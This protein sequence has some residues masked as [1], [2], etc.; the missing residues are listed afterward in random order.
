MFL[1]GRIFAV[2]VFLN[3]CPLYGQDQPDMEF[4]Q[5]FFKEGKNL[6]PL[7]AALATAT[8]H[9][10][11][12]ISANDLKGEARAL[13]GLGLLHLTRTH[14]YEKAM[15]FLIRCLAIEDS[16]QL[17]D[18]QILT[19]VG[20]AKVFEVVGDYYKSAQFLDQALKI[21]DDQRNI[22]VLVMI[23]NN[24]GKVNASMG[25]VAEAFENYELALEYKDDIDP[26]VKAE[27]LFNLGHLYTL[28][29]KYPEA[30]TSH[31]KALAITRTIRDHRREALSLNDIGEVYRL[32]KNKEKSLA[33]HMVAL[34]IRQSLNDKRG[35]AQSYNNIGLWYYKQKEIEK[36]IENVLLALE[37]GR[38]SQAQEQMFK[39]YE[40]LSQAYKDL[41]DYKNALAYKELSLA[42]N[43]FMQNERHERQ[44]L[45]TQNRYVIGKKEN[46]IENLEAQRAEREKEIIVQKRSKN[47]LIVLSTL[48]L[49]ILLLILFLYLVKQRSNRILKIAKDKVQ[50][51]NVKLQE[52]NQTKDKFFSILSHDLKGPLNSLTSFSHLLI[53]HTDSMTKDDIQ[54]LAKDLDKSVRNLYALLENLLEWSR[55]QTGNID[56]TPEVFDFADMLEMNKSLLESQ[57]K[58]KQIRI[59]IG[60]NPKCLVKVHKHSINTVVRNLISNAIKF[61]NPGGTIT[62]NV[63]PANNHISV[64]V[65]DTG[66][67]MSGE[68]ISKLFRLEKKYSS[69][70][71]ADEKGTGLGLILCKEFVEK[72]GGQIQVK[73]EAGKG[74]VFSFSFP[75]HLSE[76]VIQTTVKNASFI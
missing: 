34:E 9:L 71:T 10:D 24:L 60:S 70:G 61:T 75:Q 20:L 44:L 58:N 76:T 64:S 18:P 49:I 51:Q 73:S 33:N 14:D 29:G 74:S 15:D 63:Q 42:I 7:E 3:L 57:A 32:M 46:E 21:N 53:D 55:S 27:A 72:N 26:R 28:Q 13:K 52:L 37:N 6:P 4:F 62:L 41:G 45:E 66:I 47:F 11:Q 40:L 31:K 65:T 16:L 22:N 35:I 48:T 23:L 36:A 50:Q 38:E 8:A 5:G 54:M 12:A 39:S 19:Y 67:G 30:L 2:L 56:F 1:R 17:K 25:N 68:V 69:K 59:I 43:E